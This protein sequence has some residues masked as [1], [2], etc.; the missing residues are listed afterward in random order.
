M[1]TTMLTLVMCGTMTMMMTMLLMLV[2]SATMITMTRV[3]VQMKIL[4]VEIGIIVQ[5]YKSNT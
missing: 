4:P 5:L 3:E 2:K 1:V